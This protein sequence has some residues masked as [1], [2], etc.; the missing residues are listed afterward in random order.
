MR[1]VP[2]DDKHEDDVATVRAARDDARR[3]GV[4]A[5]LS[6]EARGSAVL[7]YPGS[8][9]HL[10]AECLVERTRD[11]VAVQRL[12]RHLISS[13]ARSESLGS[14]S[15]GIVTGFDELSCYRLDEAGWAADVDQRMLVGRP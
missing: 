14:D 13:A 3:L 4:D 7:T 12:H 15:A 10:V 1:S 9:R 5:K 2:P 11:G 8:R 6:E